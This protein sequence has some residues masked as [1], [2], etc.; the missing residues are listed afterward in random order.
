MENCKKMNWNRIVENADMA[1]ALSFMNPNL[2]GAT[3]D[4]SQRFGVVDSPDL[5]W[6]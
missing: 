2:N 4:C 1:H 5:I 6:R 3:S